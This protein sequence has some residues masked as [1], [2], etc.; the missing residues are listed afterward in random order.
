M[1]GKSEIKVFDCIKDQIITESFITDG[2]EINTPYGISVNPLNGDVYITD[3]HSYMV[4]GDVLCFSKEGKLKFRINEIGLNPNNIVFV[5]K[6][7][8][9]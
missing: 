9:E 6:K 7:I 3:A 1:T 5:N 8:S 2:T 4:W